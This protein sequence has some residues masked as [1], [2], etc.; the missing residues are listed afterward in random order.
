[1]VE[2]RNQTVMGMA[3]SMT[4]AMSMPSWFWGEAVST[5]VFTLNCTATQSVEGKTPYEAWHGSKP[6]IHF[7]RT[8]G[9]IPHVKQENL[10]FS[11]LEDRSTPMVFIGYEPGSKAWRFYN[12]TTR[13]VHVSRD[14]VFE[15]E[16][17]WNWGDGEEPGVDDNTFNVE[18]NSIGGTRRGSGEAV[19]TGLP[20]ASPAPVT[21][22]DIRYAS[23]PSA[24]PDLDI[25]QDDAPLRFR[26]MG[27]ILGPGTPPG[28]ADRDVV[29]EL[30]MAISEEPTSVEAAKQVKEWRIAML[31][32]MASIE[33]NKT[34]SR[35]DLPG[36]HRAIGLKWVFKF[37]R[38]EHGVVVKHKARLVAK[39]YI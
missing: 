39:G 35:V 26:T 20:S 2:R 8:F 5:A 23:P 14:V 18:F 31:E 33:Y 30:M 24:E 7:L 17:P 19:V 15:E 9:C 28:R 16:R 3:R 29:E 36:G 25:D 37:K 10:R 32:E 38:D 22:A 11:K 21:P 4:K 6:A 27:D 1:V 12:P 13:R 34:W